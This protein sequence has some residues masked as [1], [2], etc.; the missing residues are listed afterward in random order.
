LGPTP[1]KLQNTAG[2]DPSTLDVQPGAT[3]TS[4]AC[5]FSS[6]S[7]WEFPLKKTELSLGVVVRSVNHDLSHNYNRRQAKFLISAK[8]LTYSC[9]SDILPLRVKK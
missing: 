3:S 7:I 6:V 8:F 2:I 9:L 1:K 5:L 4:V